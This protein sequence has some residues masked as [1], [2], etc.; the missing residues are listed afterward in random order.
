MASTAPHSAVTVIRPALLSAPS[1]TF[2]LLFGGGGVVT[3]A[4]GGYNLLAE[5][6]Y[7]N[8]AAFGLLTAFFAFGLYYFLFLYTVE[9]GASSVSYGRGRGRFRKSVERDRVARITWKV[10]GARDYGLLLDADGKVL[11]TIDPTLTRKQVK[12]VADA[13]GLPLR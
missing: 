4:L 6:H 1:A 8:A 9:I 5:H 12:L 3:L 2:G 11:V 13:L 10:T 7:S